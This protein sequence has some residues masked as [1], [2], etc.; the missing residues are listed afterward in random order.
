MPPARQNAAINN[1]AGVEFVQ[2]DVFDHLAAL[3]DATV[4]VKLEISAEV[5]SGVPEDVARTVTENAK[6]LKFDQHG[7]EAQ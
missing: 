4:E 7:F 5:P 6:T 2:A 3:V 1:L